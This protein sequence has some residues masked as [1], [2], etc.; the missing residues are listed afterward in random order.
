MG[1]LEKEYDVLRTNRA[2]MPY[3]E[4]SA[5]GRGGTDWASVVRSV[6]KLLMTNI[7]RLE[8][9]RF[10]I[11]LFMALVAN[12]FVRNLPVFVNKNTQLLPV[13]WKRSVW[14][15]TEQVR[16]NQT[17]G[18]ASGRPCHLIIQVINT[19]DH[20]CLL[21]RTVIS[22]G[23]VFWW[24]Q[25]WANWYKAFSSPW[26]CICLRALIWMTTNNELLRKTTI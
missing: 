1:E 26:T 7:S 15:N 17:V 9:A 12:F 3:W 25:R 2:W 16:T 4:M 14:Q 6:K 22:F 11:S 24:I 19:A 18:F 21:I 13:P 20:H 23:K 5:R 10:V 8:Q